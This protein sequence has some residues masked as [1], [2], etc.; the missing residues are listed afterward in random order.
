MS[1][2]KKKE[3]EVGLVHGLWKSAKKNV[4]KI[5]SKKRQEKEATKAKEEKAAKT[6]KR[7]KE[8]NVVT[9]TKGGG[10]LQRKNAAA[11]RKAEILRKRRARAKAKADSNKK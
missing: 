5:G 4:L 8:R 10:K 7:R 1:T 11:A 2:T 6:A 9:G 3:E